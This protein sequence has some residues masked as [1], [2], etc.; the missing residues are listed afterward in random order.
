MNP[1]CVDITNW[2]M[3]HHI[4]Q[5]FCE[6]EELSAKE[7]K[8]Y[9]R[10]VKNPMYFSTVLTKLESGSYTSVD[11]WLS[12]VYLVFDNSIKYYGKDTIYEDIAIHMKRIVDKK[13]AEMK[14]ASSYDCWIDTLIK[15]YS[16]VD[17]I[18]Q[19]KP[20]VLP[21]CEVPTETCLTENQYDQLAEALGT[22]NDRDQIMEL[23]HVMRVSG[24]DLGP[25]IKKGVVNLRRVP[26]ITA[27]VLW[28][29]A[30][31]HKKL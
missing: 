29:W 17:R 28:N 2:L 14:S 19:N 23:C 6:P 21:E 27:K 10:K 16:K 15:L 8:Q 7:K 1:Q 13:V 3:S 20:G 24:F 26:P 18:M 11:Q 9:N 5:V 25:K 12:D 4:G 30:K 31:D 22:V